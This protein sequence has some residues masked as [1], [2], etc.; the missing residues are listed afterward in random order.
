MHAV[1]TL[2]PVDSALYAPAEHEV[3]SE[4]EDPPS[5]VPK[6]PAPHDVQLEVPDTSALYRPATH[7][8]HTADV[9][10]TV[11]LP[12]APAPH[13]VHE[14]AAVEIAPPPLY[15]PTRHPAQPPRPVC[16]P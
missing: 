13:A 9:V 2:A 8:V 7:T 11:T 15:V 12:Y 16:L 6:V 4:D 5:R 3:Q 14:G 1:H 10:A